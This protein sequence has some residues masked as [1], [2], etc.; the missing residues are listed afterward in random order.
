MPSSGG[1]ATVSPPCPGVADQIAAN[2]AAAAQ[3]AAGAQKTYVP[4]APNLAQKSCFATNWQTYTLPNSYSDVLASLATSAFNAFKDAA[5][6]AIC[7]AMVQLANL[8]G[9]TL[10]GATSSLLNTINGMGS[11]LGYA[12]AAPITNAAGNV[13]QAAGAL[14]GAVVGGVSNTAAG[15]ANTAVSGVRD[16]V[17]TGNTGSLTNF[18]TGR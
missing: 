17:G 10:N 9:N 13:S 5:S 3:N 14:Q 11:S 15:A 12:A 18:L 16:A 7:S 8:P 4:D 1:S 6:S 2:A